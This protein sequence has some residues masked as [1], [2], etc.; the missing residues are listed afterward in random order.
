MGEEGA[1]FS[2]TKVGVIFPPELSN[3]PG[4]VYTL[5]FNAKRIY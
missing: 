3:E 1:I 5:Y 4:N 2:S